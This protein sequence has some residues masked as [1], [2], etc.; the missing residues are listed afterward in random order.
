M[1]LKTEK[2]I[3]AWYQDQLEGAV[4]FDKTE[5]RILDIEISK[6]SRG[7]SQTLEN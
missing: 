6:F 2:W 3:S 7:I 1:W 5:N 4:C